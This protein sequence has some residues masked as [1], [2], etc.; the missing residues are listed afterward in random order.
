MVAPLD[1]VWNTGAQASAWRRQAPGSRQ[2]QQQQQQQGG[3]GGRR[4]RFNNSA[5]PAPSCSMSRRHGST[6]TLDPLC[7]LYERGR[8]SPS[9]G[10]ASAVSETMHQRAKVAPRPVAAPPFAD[11]A[12]SSRRSSSRADPLQQP[13]DDA[14]SSMGYEFVSAEGASSRSASPVGASALGQIDF[15]EWDCDADADEEDDEDGEGLPVTSRM[16][17]RG[18]TTDVMTYEDFEEEEAEEEEESHAPPTVAPRPP[19]APPVAPRP[20]SAPPSPPP[21]PPKAVERYLPPP[22]TAVERYLPQPLSA[23]APPTPTPVDSAAFAMDMGLYVVSG[24]MLIFL[25]EQFIQIGVRLH[26]R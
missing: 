6:S 16:G 15:Y 9:T 24:V 23:Q 10:N 4:T 22:P 20:P 1:E 19:S 7:D 5:D 26:N 8:G 21:P 13:M 25:M 17:V 18:S 12:R 3:R 11:S 2:P 14:V